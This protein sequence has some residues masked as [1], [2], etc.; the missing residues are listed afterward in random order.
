V[1]L[2][3]FLEEFGPAPDGAL[4]LKVGTGRPV[5]QLASEATELIRRFNLGGSLP[6][7]VIFYQANL[8]AEQLP[9]LYRS[10]DAFVL[11]TRGEGW[12]RPLIEAMLKGVPSIAT[13]WSGQL[14]FMNDENSWLVDCRLVDVPEP[15]WRAAA[16]FHGHRWAEPDLAHSRRA[17]REVFADREAARSRAARGREEI[18]TRFNRRA[19]ADVVRAHLLERLG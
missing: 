12:G 1:L 11:P 19:V 15:A 6:P 9:Q 16:I 5:Q 3:A 13:R 14:E 2:R 7:N 4:I 8:P 10:A 18:A 17:M